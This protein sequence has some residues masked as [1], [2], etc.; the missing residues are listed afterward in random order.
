MLRK[1]RTWTL[2][3]DQCLPGKELLGDSEH[4]QGEDIEDMY[5]TLPK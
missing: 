1:W 3:F 5:S 4:Q 2:S